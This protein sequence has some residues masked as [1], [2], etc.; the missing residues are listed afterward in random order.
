MAQLVYLY[1]FDPDDFLARV[2]SERILNAD[3]ITELRNRLEMVDNRARHITKR[4][5]K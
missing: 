5:F 3:Q 2:K 1:G 4:T